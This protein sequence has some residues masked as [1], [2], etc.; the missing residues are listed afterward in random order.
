VACPLAQP[1]FSG[2]TPGFA[3]LYQVNF[4]VPAPPPG[5]PAC[6]SNP[7]RI[8]SNLTVTLIG[9][10]SFDGGGICVDTTGNSGS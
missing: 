10:S 2:L 9:L 4:I 6:S 3:G 8:D 5:T 7:P 1:I